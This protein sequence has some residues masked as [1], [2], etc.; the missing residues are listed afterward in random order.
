MQRFRKAL[1]HISL[2]WLYKNCKQLKL[3]FNIHVNYQQLQQMDTSGQ[4]LV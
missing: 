3:S 4:G 2:Y 1:R